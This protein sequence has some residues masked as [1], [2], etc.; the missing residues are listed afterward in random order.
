MLRRPTRGQSSSTADWNCIPNRTERPTEARTE[1]TERHRS[2]CQPGGHQRILSACSLQS[3][4]HC[5]ADTRLRSTKTANDHPKKLRD[6][7]YSAPDQHTQ[8]PA[9]RLRLY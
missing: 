2:H 9:S 8:G 7:P 6:A 4:A 3:G 5:F 1:I